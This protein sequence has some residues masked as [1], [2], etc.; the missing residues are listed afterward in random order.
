MYKLVSDV[1]GSRWSFLNGYYIF[2]NVVWL[3]SLEEANKYTLID[4][5]G[6]EI[7][8]DISDFIVK[9]W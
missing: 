6:K 3:S 2:S 4:E 5:N 7:D 9:A 8:V 1:K